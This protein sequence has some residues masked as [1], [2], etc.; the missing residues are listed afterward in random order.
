MTKKTIADRRI[1]RV[2]P[3]SE[4]QDNVSIAT[5]SH[6]WKQCPR[7]ENFPARSRTFFLYVEATY[8]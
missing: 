2:K 1:I 6:L 7:R 5:S 4:K 8:Q 3:N